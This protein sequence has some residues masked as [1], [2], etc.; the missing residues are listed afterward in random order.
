MLAC[1]GPVD[2]GDHPSGTAGRPRVGLALS[3]GGARGFAHI[4]VM[5]VLAEWHIPI[6]M[7]AGTSMGS[8]VGGLRALGYSEEELAKIA[9]KVDWQGIF[10]DETP[11]EALFY[12]Q[13]QQAS[14]FLVQLGVRGLKLELPSGLSAGQKIFNLFSLLTLPAAGIKDF[15]HLPVPY[16]AVA[17]DL[18]TGKEVVLDGR[19][20]SLAESMRASM[21]V[22]G[23]FM[24]VDSGEMLLVDGGLVKNLPV[25]VVRKMRCGRGHRR[26]RVGAPQD[27]SGARLRSSRRGPD[28]LPADGQIDPGASGDR[29]P[30][31]CPDYPG[32]ARFGLHG[33]RSRGED[34][35]PG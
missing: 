18:V 17:T 7:I 8:V 29:P 14:K 24:P 3:G 4:G 2:A 25:D 10:R 22:P 32:P 27:Q 19:R 1:V 34:H 30:A 20:L 16:R 33:L 31:R 15:D 23:A 11:R 6:D 13:K 12:G 21:S 26:R 5:K 35:A 28:H 9:T